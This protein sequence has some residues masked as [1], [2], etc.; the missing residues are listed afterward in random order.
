MT[1]ALAQLVAYGAQDVYL[2]GNP[3]TTFWKQVFNR[4]TN[5]A[6]ETIEQDVVG[7]VD[8]G[9][10]ISVTLGR[11]GD[12]VKGVM[13]EITLQRGSTDPDLQQPYFEC[14]HLIDQLELWIGGQKILN[15]DHEWF[16]MYWEIYLNLDQENA[17]RDMCDFQ[18]ET[19]GY[20]RTFYLPL[21][22][23]FNDADDNNALP[24]IA[25]QYHE[26]Q[27]RL[28]LMNAQYMV[29][30][31]T[32]YTPT[33]K[34]LA[35]YVFLD[36]KERI[37][38]AQNS[39]EYII[40]QIQRNIFP[41]TVNQ[42]NNSF[43]LNLNFNH[44]TQILFWVLVPSLTTHGQYTADPGEQN[45][46]ILAPLYK[47]KLTINGIDR[48]KDFLGS[49][50]G[51]ANP[52]ITCNGNYT[53]SGVYTYGFGIRTQYGIPSG[54]MNFS[55]IDNATLHITTKAATVVDQY[56]PGVVNESMTVVG[57][58]V[59]TMALVYAVNFNVFRIQSG[60]GGVAFA[61]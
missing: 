10:D 39:H 8:Y 17:Y 22:L 37:W 16:R 55:R 4:Y 26:V 35:T 38:F 21:P 47:C 14:E 31:N 61:N 57:A 43:K 3:S 56:L 5:F 52:W 2:T 48:M 29:G 13:L 15:F 25:L 32:A 45:A 7:A 19:E 30:I 20:I 53:S 51:S 60:M 36:S 23:W 50:Y 46:D 28:K 42:N 33:I 54:T 27:L 58:N 34:C 1:G 12:L 11:N 44:P 9:Q 24:L 49:Y 41:V 40:T 59:L 18:T 6:L